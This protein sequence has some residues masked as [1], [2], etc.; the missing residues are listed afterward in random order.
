MTMILA[1]DLHLELL[2][3]CIKQKMK[4]A[5]KVSEKSPTEI[6]IVDPCCE[7]QKIQES[8]KVKNCLEVF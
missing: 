5:E 8:S 3:Q 4:L 1:F 2:I 7:K 6:P